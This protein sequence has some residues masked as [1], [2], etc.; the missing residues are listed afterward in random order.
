[1]INLGQASCNNSKILGLKCV[2][3]SVFLSVCTGII[4]ENSSC[5][6]HDILSACVCLSVSTNWDNIMT[7]TVS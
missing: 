7:L 5:P 1:M 6:N 2:S 4:S 3:L